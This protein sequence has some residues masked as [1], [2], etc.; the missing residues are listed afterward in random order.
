MRIA[1]CATVAV[2]GLAVATFA[3]GRVYAEQTRQPTQA[4]L[5]AAAATGVAQR[6]E[7]VPAG[8]VFPATIGYATDLQTKET[9]TRLGMTSLFYRRVS[10]DC[11][12]DSISGAGR[13]PVVRPASLPSLNTAIV[14]IDMIRNRSPRSGS[15][16]VFTL[17]MR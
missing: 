11:M 2:A 5:S 9:A 8:G 6:W 4:E 10:V 15:A 13:A 3:G 16:S 14:G 1:A 17:T 12:N 7:R